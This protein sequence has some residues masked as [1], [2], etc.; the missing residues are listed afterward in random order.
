MLFR[1][2]YRAKAN[3]PPFTFHDL[4]ILR[5]ATAFNSANDVTGFLIRDEYDYFQ[6]LEGERQTLLDLAHRIAKDGRIYG[7]TD[8]WSGQIDARLFD[9]WAMGFH[10]LGQADNGL[11]Y[12]LSLLT[13]WTT[14]T[15]KQRAIRDMAQLAIDKYQ[16]A[17][18]GH[19]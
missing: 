1:L 12:R 8:I 5:T 7:Y 3:Y 13:P 2:L 6:V 15:L 4:D 14:P 18:S 17:T 11:P 9:L 16:G 10:I 19:S